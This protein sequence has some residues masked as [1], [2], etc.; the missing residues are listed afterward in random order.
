MRKAR[1]IVTENIKKAS[2]FIMGILLICLKVIVDIKKF[3]FKSLEVKWVL[4]MVRAKSIKK[5]SKD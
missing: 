1:N 5:V 3:D 2:I 4:S